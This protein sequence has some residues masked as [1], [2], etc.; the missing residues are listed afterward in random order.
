[1]DFNRSQ[2]AIIHNV[3]S[4]KD[5]WTHGLLY[6]A[7]LHNFKYQHYTFMHKYTRLPCLFLHEP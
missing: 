1:M 6:Y 7:V 4:G 2:N 3:Q 5:A